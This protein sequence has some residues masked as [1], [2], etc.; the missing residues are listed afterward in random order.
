MGERRA[1]VVM[2]MERRGDVDV[3]PKRFEQ[4]K[5]KQHGHKITGSMAQGSKGEHGGRRETI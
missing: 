2:V 5:A 1:V 3:R 4:R